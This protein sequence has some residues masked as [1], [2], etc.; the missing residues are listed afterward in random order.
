ME[1]CIAAVCK[2]FPPLSY[3]A[4]ASK[5]GTS[6][7]SGAG[8]IDLTSYAK[9][10]DLNAVA[11]VQAELQQ[12]LP[13][14]EQ[15]VDTVQK[16]EGPRGAKGD[17]GEKGPRG[18]K[19]DKGEKGPR[20]AKGDKGEKG[21]RGETGE[22]GP[23]GEQ[24]FQGEPGPAG[25]R[26][27]KG[28]RG[29]AG[30]TGLQG[31]RGEPGT[32]GMRGLKGEKGE[33]GGRGKQGLQGETGPKGDTGEKGDKG[34]RGEKGLQGLRGNKGEKGDKGDR[35]EQGPRGNK[36]DTGPRGESAVGRLFKSKHSFEDDL[37]C[38]LWFD[39][40]MFNSITRSGSDFNITNSTD[41][42][43]HD[44]NR[45]SFKQYNTTPIVEKLLA[46]DADGLF[47]LKQFN[48]PE[49]SLET[50]F[51]YQGLI[52]PTTDITLIAVYSVPTERDANS[53]GYSPITLRGSNA[54]NLTEFRLD[55]STWYDRQNLADK[56][57][58]YIPGSS[59][60]IDISGTDLSVVVNLQKATGKARVGDL[61]GRKI[62]LMLERAH[63]GQHRIY[64]NG[65]EIYSHTDTTS[66]LSTYIGGSIRI[67][68]PNIGSTINSS[69]VYYGAALLRRLTDTEKLQYVEALREVYRF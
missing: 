32:Q 17:K 22:T 16:S 55:M 54:T 36:G 68:A 52:T 11:R 65:V 49:Y 39:L 3:K 35:G 34:D 57:V 9:R 47:Y 61:A 28:D 44:G 5:F 10:T 27:E 67:G 58:L 20:G 48:T 46:K 7:S 42:V 4:M 13:T 12:K 25:L 43:G 15:K 38:Q 60:P 53:F 41:V 14:I 30:A 18:A 40:S 50:G 63:T 2:N 45:Y 23:M 1:S 56:F 59:I 6:L 26:G 31:A 51:N 33:K 24:G 29:E 62:C 37:Y 21:D 69:N 64:I 8:A 19:G 66:I